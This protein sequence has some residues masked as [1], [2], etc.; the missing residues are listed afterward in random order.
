VSVFA[1]DFH[2]RFDGDLHLR[3][4]RRDLQ[5]DALSLAQRATALR[6]GA[7]QL[8]ECVRELLDT[9]IDQLI[10]NVFQRDTVLLQLG[11]QSAAS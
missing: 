4:A 10:G 8:V 2:L 6:D 11:E 1:P 9:V 3:R 5:A 7:E